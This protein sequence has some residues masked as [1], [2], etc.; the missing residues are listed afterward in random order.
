[1]RE[2]YVLD[3][4]CLLIYKI[5]HPLNSFDSIKD[6]I[7][8]KYTYTAPI[9]IYNLI[10][11][12]FIFTKLH[13]KSVDVAIEPIF[14]Y[15]FKPWI[16]LFSYRPNRNGILDY[17]R[18]ISLDWTHW[19]AIMYIWK[20]GPVDARSA[21]ETGLNRHQRVLFLTWVSKSC[22]LY[23]RFRLDSRKPHALLVLRCF[24]PGTG[25]LSACTRSI[26]RHYRYSLLSGG[27]G[28]S[29]SL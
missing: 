25:Q 15:S 28:P 1:M 2:S 17:S 23:L 13:E 16:S 24:F 19:N 8:L 5:Y 11:W 26:Y 27:P 21:M 14:P 4:C 6:R 20:I 3:Y 9:K 18:S 7:F 12:I 10:Q 29:G 22:S